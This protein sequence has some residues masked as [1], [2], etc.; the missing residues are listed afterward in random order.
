MAL[1]DE[2]I[3]YLLHLQIGIPTSEQINLR[4]V[5]N[6]ELGS[7]SDTRTAI[8]MDASWRSICLQAPT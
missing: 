8:V 6:I 7:L 1:S 2:T 3:P 4:P 5:D